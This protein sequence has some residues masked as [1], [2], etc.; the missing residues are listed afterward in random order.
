MRWPQLSVEQRF[1]SHVDKTPR[2]GPNGNCWIWTASN[3]RYGCFYPVDKRVYAH[4]FSWILANGQIPKGKHI[5][6]K[7]DN[8]ICVRPDHLYIGTQLENI[9]DRQKKNRQAIGARIFTTKLTEP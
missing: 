5:L 6:H 3:H 7:C 1:W 2:H 8:T 4:I 9:A